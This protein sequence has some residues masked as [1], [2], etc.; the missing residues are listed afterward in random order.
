MECDAERSQVKAV[1]QD[2]LARTHAFMYV[3][4]LSINFNRTLQEHQILFSLQEMDMEV[5]EVKLAKE[6]VHCLHSFDGRDLPTELEDVHARVARV[7]D[8]CI[9][10]ARELSRLVMEIS[11]AL[12]DL[13]MLS[14]WDIPQLP[15]MA[16]EVLVVASLILECLREEHASGVGP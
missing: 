13:G 4:K 7:E 12:V 14:I 6:Q 9:V 16:Q 10:E 15:R 1:R 2:Y 5:W 8:E 11:N 3:P